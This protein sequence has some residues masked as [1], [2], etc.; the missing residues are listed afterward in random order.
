MAQEKRIHRIYQKR[1]EAV[2]SVWSY[3]ESLCE[4]DVV[5]VSLSCVYPAVPVPKIVIAIPK[6]RNT[7]FILSASPLSLSAWF[8]SCKLPAG[9]AADISSACPSSLAA[10]VSW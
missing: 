2:I 3:V 6:G 1:C 8:F 9:L 7:P 5:S 4:A 10:S